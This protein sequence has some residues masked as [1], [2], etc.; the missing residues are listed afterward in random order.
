M[1]KADE[2]AYVAYQQGESRELSVAF[3]LRNDK[4]NQE[5]HAQSCRTT[6]TGTAVRHRKEYRT[7]NQE[8][9]VVVL[10]PTEEIVSILI[11]YRTLVK[12]VELYVDGR[13]MQ[14]DA[15]ALGKGG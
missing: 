15:A 1:E 11:N 5:I 12:L 6:W 14:G 13:M 2:R 4:A 3:V 10:E 9:G 7:T 8:G